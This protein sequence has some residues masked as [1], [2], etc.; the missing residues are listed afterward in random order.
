MS[1]F[2]VGFTY[3]VSG[4][5]SFLLSTK[6]LTTHFFLCSVLSVNTIADICKSKLLNC[7]T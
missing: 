7:T 2:C 4:S 3:W 1:T 5:W 6:V